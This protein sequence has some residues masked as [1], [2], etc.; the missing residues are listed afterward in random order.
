MALLYLRYVSLILLYSKLADT[1]CY[2]RRRE[3]TSA[4]LKRSM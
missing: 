1:F 4:L 3:E 2:Y